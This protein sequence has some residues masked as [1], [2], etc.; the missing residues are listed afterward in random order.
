[1]QV[2]ML[3]D[4][5]RWMMIV[6]DVGNGQEGMVLTNEPG[7]YFIESEIEAALADADKAKYMVWRL[8]SYLV[9]A[10]VL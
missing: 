9:H 1:M 6:R 3:R 8:P 7:C 5:V 10:C 4:L 2:M